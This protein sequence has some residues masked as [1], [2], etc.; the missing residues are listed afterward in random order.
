VICWLSE[1]KGA[2]SGSVPSIRFGDCKE[3]HCKSARMPHGLRFSLGVV[4]LKADCILGGDVKPEGFT[5]STETGLPWGVGTHLG[6]KRATRPAELIDWADRFLPRTASV[7][8]T[9]VPRG[10]KRNGAEERDDEGQVPE[11]LHS[12]LGR[13]DGFPPSLEEDTTPSLNGVGSS[14]H[15]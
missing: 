3:R 12:G 2:L 6:V 13:E 15:C 9:T 1:D 7:V 14:R 4:V 5:A 11:E 10:F 8:E